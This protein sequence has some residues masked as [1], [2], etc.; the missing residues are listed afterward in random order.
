MLPNS[1]QFYPTSRKNPVVETFETSLNVYCLI[2]HSLKITGHTRSTDDEAT[3][4]FAHLE[5]QECAQIS[6]W[7]TFESNATGS[8]TGNETGPTKSCYSARPL[9]LS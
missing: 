2:N 9:S 3:Q 5:M 6:A 4:E 7:L 1:V 8:E